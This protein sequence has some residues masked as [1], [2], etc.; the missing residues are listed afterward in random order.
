MLLCLILWSE[1]KAT[2]LQSFLSLSHSPL[3]LE[4]LALVGR[5]VGR[6]SPSEDLGLRY[7]VHTAPC[8]YSQPS[9]ALLYSQ[10]EDKEFDDLEERFQWVSLCVSELKSNVAAYLDNLEV[11]ILQFIMGRAELGSLGRGEVFG[12]RRT[13]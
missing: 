12:A 5:S 11:R 3:G 4:E 1:Y 6:W 9:Q 8:G 7:G 13:I 10:T 2:K